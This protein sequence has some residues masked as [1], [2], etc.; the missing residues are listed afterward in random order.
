MRP[1]LAGID[2]EYGILVEGRGAEDQVED[3]QALVESYS[4]EGCFIGWDYRFENPRN[5]LRGFQL[6]K[7]EVDPNDAQF[8]VGRRQQS[9]IV[10]RADRVL[11]N[12]ARFYNDHGHPEYATPESFSIFELAALDAEGQRFV[13]RV[14]QRSGMD[15]KLYKNNTDYHGASYGTH[16]SYLVPRRYDFEAIY[17]AVTPMLIVR[18]ILTG[19]GK[20]GGEEGGWCD[21]QLSQRA[22]FFVEPANAETLWRRPIFNTRDEPHADPA[23]WVRLHIISGDAN[24]NPASTALKVGLVKLALWLLDAGTAPTW[25]IERP[26]RTFQ[27]VSR[28][29][30]YEYRIELDK[31]NWTNAYEIFESYFAAAEQT[32]ALNE[33]ARWTIDTSRRLLVALREDWETFRREADWAAKFHFLNQIREEEGLSWRAP[34]LQAYDLEY[35]NIDPNDGLFDALRDMD[36]IA[37]PDFPDLQT[38]NSRALARSLAITKF[39]PHLSNVGWRGL[40]FGEEFVELRPDLA[41]PDS[42]RRL[43]DVET[44]IQ[45][46]KD[47]HASI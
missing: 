24:M 25:P 13:H 26:V 21:F 8:D 40:Q 34:I 38:P 19:A 33:E 47:I 42:I 36:E 28:D 18:Q 1:I 7:L 5:D 35:T 16:E 43:D 44:F 29:R 6:S 3:S 20:V 45:S 14:G 2:C 15:V 12:G 30:T 32:L 27:A 37:K 39:K 4:D 46:L 10:L 31:G 9:S 17:R 23:Q 22:D 41:Y 11:P